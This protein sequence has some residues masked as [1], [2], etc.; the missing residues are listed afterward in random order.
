MWAFPDDRALWLARNVVPFEPALRA[1]LARWHL[2][3]DLDTDDIIQE[4]YARLASH[5]AIDEIR[6]PRNYFRQIAKSIVLAHIRHS[7]IVFIRAIDN[8]ESLDVDS[9]E[10]DPE[11]Q[12][13]DR[14]Q[15]QLLADAVQQLPEASR[16]AFMLRVIEGLSHRE[17][18]E[19][20]GLSDN[21]VQKSIAK[22]LALLVTRLSRGGN[23][24]SEASREKWNREAL[25]SD[26]RQGDQRRD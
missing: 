8:L 7:K 22:S 10:P 5:K 3:E 17:I 1:T 24:S 13:S 16:K 2:P 20:L 15:L 6:S 26:E 14:Q 21:A 19:R 12:V 9:G 25:L 4:A 11:Q 18:G 23:D